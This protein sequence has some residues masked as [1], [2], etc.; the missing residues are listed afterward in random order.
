MLSCASAPRARGRYEWDEEIGGKGTILWDAADQVYKAWY[1]SQPGIDYTGYNSS[2]G[3]SRMMTYA[4]SNDGL[5]WDRPLLPIV[6]WNGSDSNILIRLDN[7]EEVSYSCVFIDHGNANRSRTY[8]MFLLCASAPPGFA[9]SHGQVIYRY[10]SADGINWR[11]ENVISAGPCPG[12]TWCSD[13]LYIN[14]LADGSLFAILKHGPSN[15]A[16]PGQLSPFDIAAG[17]TRWIYVSSS[18][19]NGLSWTPAE[20][21]LSPDWRDPQDFQVISSISTIQAGNAVIGW[22]PVFHTLSQT[23]DMQFTAS[24]DGGRTWWRPERRSAVPFREL[25]YYGGGM[26]WPYRLFVP[27]HADPTKLH[28]YFS[29]CQGR[30]ADIHSTLPGERF[31]EMREQWTSFGAWGYRNLELGS[32]TSAESYSPIRS[33]NWFR[34]ALMRATWDSS[35]LWAL[36]PAAGG[37]VPGQALTTTHENK[38]GFELF[39][40]V[41]VH[42]QTRTGADGQ[43]AVEIIDAETKS[44]VPGFTLDDATPVTADTKAGAVRWRGGTKI[45]ASPS[46]FMLRFVLLR[47]R[48]YSWKWCTAGG[49][50]F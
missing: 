20:L 9:K 49:C 41:K 5:A 17:G 18:T 26:M 46:K 3:A 31:A 33:T 32:K 24:L 38:G 6:K 43:V 14:K 44:P 47:A 27:D 28:A 21:S 42:N 11:P 10:F 48:L 1:I 36:I 4:T 19:D 50:I 8:E 34:G 7:M 23:I 12:G 2:E 29:G 45:P 35:R 30:H 39:V 16:G 37:D 40:N 15:G 25:G 22:L 13:S